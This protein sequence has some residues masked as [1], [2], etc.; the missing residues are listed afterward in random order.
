VGRWLA[1][2]VVTLI[3]CW[4]AVV[5]IRAVAHVGH[6]VADGGLVALF[7]GYCPCREGAEFGEAR[8]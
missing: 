1:Q 8:A 3:V 7:L 2:Q 5:D 6:T 4:V